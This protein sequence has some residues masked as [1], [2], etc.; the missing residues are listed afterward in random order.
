MS[1]PLI[2]GVAVI[3]PTDWVAVPTPAIIA[4]TVNVISGYAKFWYPT[5]VEPKLT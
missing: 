5:P 4:S 3:T 1:S 2:I